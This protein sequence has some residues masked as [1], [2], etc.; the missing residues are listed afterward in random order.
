MPP[1]RIWSPASDGAATQELDDA[2][3]IVEQEWSK[4]TLTS[5][6]Y[7]LLKYNLEYL[8]REVDG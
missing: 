4:G 7:G 2:L 8:R 5:E 6:G 1:G 3:A